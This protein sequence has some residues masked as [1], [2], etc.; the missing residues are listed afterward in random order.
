MW[1]PPQRQEGGSQ[2]IDAV[3]G[4]LLSTGLT[5][6]DERQRAEA[7][8]RASG[9]YTGDED[10]IQHEA[11][12][13]AGAQTAGNVGST[14]LASAAAGAVAG[15]VIP[16]AGTVA[17]LLVG[18][19]TGVLMNVGFRDTDGDGEKDS[20]AEMI[21]DKAEKAFNWLRGKK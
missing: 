18:V 3:H 11:R 21:G 8:V 20:V 16:G 2:K 12:M 13:R 5:Y 15:S 4:T 7:N 9:Q 10:A 17:G 14:I 19:A 6:Q 1:K